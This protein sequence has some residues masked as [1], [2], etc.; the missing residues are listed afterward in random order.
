MAK[1]IKMKAPKMRLPKK[2][3]AGDIIEVR[4]K[5]RHASITGLKAVDEEKGIFER[6][7]PAI[8]L[9]KMDVI[10]DGQIITEYFMTSATSP[11]PLIRFKM[12]A[13]KEA[14]LKIVFTNSFEDQ[15]EVTKNIKFSG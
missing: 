8:Y 3:K 4:V 15:S 9:K 7:K 10:Y 13:D 5:I 6:D 11:D 2:I 12:R 14:P 1:K